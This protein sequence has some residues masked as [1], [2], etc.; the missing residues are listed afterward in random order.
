MHVDFA[1]LAVEPFSKV[2]GLRVGRDCKKAGDPGVIGY[3]GWHQMNQAIYD[4]ARQLN[5]LMYV[6]PFGKPTNP[7]A[8]HDLFMVNP[9]SPVAKELESAL[10]ANRAIP[11][12]DPVDLKKYHS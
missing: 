10:I 1:R 12:S 3:C 9:A 8:R 7:T 5:Y 11:I 2:R 6:V 4:G